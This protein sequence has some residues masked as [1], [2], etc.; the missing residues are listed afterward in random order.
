MSAKLSVTAIVCSVLAV[1]AAPA[2]A[3]SPPPG[4]LEVVEVSQE[5]SRLQ[6]GFGGLLAAPVGEFGTFVPGGAGGILGHF[7]FGLGGTFLS[8]GVE[9]GWMR[10]G[11]HTR[12]VSLGSVIPDVP[13]ASI[14]VNTSNDMVTL[15]GRIRAQTMRGRWRPYVDGL[16]GLT[17]IYTMSRVE[18]GE[19]CDQ[20]Y[21]KDF[22]ENANQTQSNDLALSYG[23]GVG[24][25]VGIGSK[26]SAPKLDFSVRYLKGGRAEYL[27]KG[28][29]RTEGE[30]VIR[31]LHQSRTDMVTVY[32][33]VAFGR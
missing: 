9:T 28:A 19:Q 15:H 18:S 7:G 16:I 21:C 14:R 32:I 25:M 22:V 8:V 30:Q 3:Q 13:D 29:L 24:L 17:D 1:S 11:N 23:G 6:G 26:R 20:F 5:P 33:G 4:T 31:D 27:T 2:A 12:T 10:Y